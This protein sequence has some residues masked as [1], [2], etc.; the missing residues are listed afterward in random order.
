MTSDAGFPTAGVSCVMLRV[1]GKNEGHPSSPENAKKQKMAG[2]THLSPARSTIRPNHQTHQEAHQTHLRAHQ[3][4]Q[5]ANQTHQNRLRPE[6]SGTR[7]RIPRRPL[8]IPLFISFPHTG[9]K[10]CVMECGK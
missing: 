7:Y 10:W 9:A 4:H 5:E 1:T 8:R 2:R 6:S 3:T